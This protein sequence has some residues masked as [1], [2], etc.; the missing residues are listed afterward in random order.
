MTPENTWD[1]K[2]WLGTGGSVGLELGG[3][4]EASEEESEGSEGL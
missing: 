3:V 1:S 4:R 2:D